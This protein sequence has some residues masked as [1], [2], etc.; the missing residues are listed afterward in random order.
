MRIQSFAILLSYIFFT[1][2][3]PLIGSGENTLI[4][5]PNKQVVEKAVAV[6]SDG[7]VLLFAPETIAT[8]CIRQLLDEERTRIMD[9]LNVVLEY[10]L[11]REKNYTR[12]LVIK[13]YEGQFP[14]G[15]KSVEYRATIPKIRDNVYVFHVLIDN[16]GAGFVLVI[17]PSIKHI[18]D[19]Y[20]LDGVKKHVKDFAT[21][22]GVDVDTIVVIPVSNDVVEPYEEWWSRAILDQL[23]WLFQEIKEH[24]IT[25]SVGYDMGIPVF[26]V[27]ARILDT[28]SGPKEFVELI[29]SHLP[30]GDWLLIQLL[31]E[32]ITLVKQLG[33]LNE[34]AISP[35]F[36]LPNQL[37]TSSVRENLPDTSRISQGTWTRQLPTIPTIII[38]TEEPSKQITITI[39][40]WRDSR[41]QQLHVI[42][43]V[44]ILVI[45]SLLL[46]IGV[47]KREV[48]LTS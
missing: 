13:Y 11:H 39:Y 35:Y 10:K 2:I 33:R 15:V 40:G 18:Y 44:G 32:P 45:T 43:L 7:R 19:D 27:E 34:T 20:V 38:K 47:K 3:F 17:V 4:V 23:E 36:R 30:E 5:C 46:A 14:W 26:D 1:S 24:R 37:N 21:S 8:D 42:V 48:K 28:V 12:G 41:E 22:Y 25:Y 6:S 16:K 31:S 29:A 9:P